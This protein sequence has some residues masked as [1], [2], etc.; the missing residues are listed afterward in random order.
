MLKDILVHVD[1]AEQF[2][3]PLEAAVYLAER[4]NAHLG[5]IL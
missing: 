1:H 2:D 4:F 5:G 3:G